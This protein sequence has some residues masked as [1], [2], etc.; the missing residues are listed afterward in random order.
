[1]IIKS[2]RIYMEDGCKSGYLEIEDGIIKQYYPDDSPV[3]A[4]VDYGNNRIIPG[5]F[6]SHNHGGFGVSV[7]DA[8][9]EDE[10]KQYLKGA[11]ANGVTALFPT[12]IGTA[13]GA[14]RL[15]S[16]MA[17]NVQDGAKIM[18]IHSEG[19]WGARVGEKGINTGYPKVDLEHAQELYDACNGK[20]KLIGIAPEVEDADKAIDFFLSK[21]VTVAMYH[22]NANY[23]QANLAIDRGITVATHLGN[24]MTGLHHRDVG[25]MGAAILR[26]EVWCELICDG[27]HVSLPM[28]DIVLRL[29]DHGKIIMVS[30]STAY[31][32]APVGTYRSG[33]QTGRS[34]RDNIHVTEEGFVLS[35]TGRLS[36]SSKPVIYGM[37]NLVEKLG[38][39]LEEVVKLSSYNVHKKYGTADKKGSIKVGKDADIVVISDSFDVLYTYSEGR[40]VYDHKVDTDLFNQR[41][42]EKYKVD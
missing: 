29:K 34:D 39:P 40:L 8:A 18:G 1:M 15:L 5:I 3:K 28:I 24:V 22:T 36:G 19:P 31:A 4:D 21:G 12:T 41:F 32:G 10:L 16:K 42:V 20:L 30:D 27:L 11:A 25:A 9:T 38:L 17:D 13:L 33:K 23:E 26:D 7:S 6:D 35:S 14:M 37:K 2:S